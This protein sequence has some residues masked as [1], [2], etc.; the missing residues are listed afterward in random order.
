MIHDYL[1]L[2]VNR[3]ANHNKAGMAYHIPKLKIKIP[4]FVDLPTGS[5]VNKKDVIKNKNVAMTVVIIAA[6]FI[7][8]RIKD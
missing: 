4:S 3:Y 2:F 1:P 8:Y 6:V 5:F 7:L